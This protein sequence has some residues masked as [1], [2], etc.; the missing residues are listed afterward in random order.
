MEQMWQ[1]NEY[2]QFILRYVKWR[3][4]RD[5]VP[6][7]SGRKPELSCELFGEFKNLLEMQLLRTPEFESGWLEL[8]ANN[9]QVDMDI[10]DGLLAEIKID[11]SETS[12]KIKSK[13][14]FTKELREYEMRKGVNG[15]TFVIPAAGLGKRMQSHFPG[16]PKAL[17]PVA[18]KSMIDHVLDAI[19]AASILADPPIVVVVSPEVREPLHKALTGRR[20]TFATQSVPRGTGDAVRAAAA[21]VPRSSRA[22]AVLFADQPLISAGSIRKLIETHY[23]TNADITMATVRLK[24]FQGWRS[25]FYDWGRI[26]RDK[27][28][29][30]VN[31]IEARDATK[32]QLDLTEV[33]PSLYCFRAPWIWNGLSRI[34]T[35]NA[36]GEYLLTDIILIAVKDSLRIET[37]TITEPLETMGANTPQ[38]L[39]ILEESLL[40]RGA[41]NATIPAE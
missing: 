10:I 39:K 33:N 22:I 29:A 20:I 23:Q 24:D 25:A 11:L 5:R 12:D 15:L 14:S 7:T 38:Q 41:T 28:G 17:I 2:V 3:R 35:G 30:V 21:R 37:I 16:I 36:Q 18:G 34:S 32:A 13:H 19:N 4:K 40:K 8:K 9:S 31:I 6:V 1:D 26:I 27:H